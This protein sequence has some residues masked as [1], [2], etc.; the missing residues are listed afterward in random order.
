MASV[1]HEFILEF[2]DVIM[3]HVPAKEKLS[4]GEE[5]IKLCDEYGFSTMDF[6][7][8]VEHSKIL[9]T[10]HKQYFGVDEDDE[11]EDEDW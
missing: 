3:K 1:D 5:L 11:D 10:A 8:I 2:W 7:D 9:E 4:L 6:D